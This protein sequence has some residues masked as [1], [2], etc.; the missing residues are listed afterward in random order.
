MLLKRFLKG[1]YA[2]LIVRRS[3]AIT[4]LLAALLKYHFSNPARSDVAGKLRCFWEIC[5]FSVY[6][7]FS[8][9]LS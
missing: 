7:W 3:G 2:H 9:G 8:W 6:N 5:L 4:S 1:K